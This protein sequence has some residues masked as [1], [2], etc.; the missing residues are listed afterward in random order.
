MG[1]GFSNT[2]SY[3]FNA[4]RLYFTFKSNVDANVGT[5]FSILFRKLF[6]SISQ[7]VKNVFDRT[8]FFDVTKAAIRAGWLNNTPVGEFSTAMGIWNEASGSSSTAMGSSSK[9]RGQSSTALGNNC[10]ASGNQSVAMGNGAVAS[11]PNAIALGAGTYATSSSSVAMGANTT[12]SGSYSTAMG[13]STIASGALSFAAGSEVN[14]NLRKGAFAFGDSDPTNQGETTVGLDDQ[15]VCRFRSGYYFLTSGNNVAT[16]T[17]VFVVTG[18]NSWSAVSDVRLK[19]NFLPVD[20]ESFL[21][22]ISLIPQY[23][24][25]YKGQ[26]SKTFRHYGPMAQDFY[27]A[28]GKDR[29]GSIGCDTLINQQDFLGVNLIVVQ[30]LEK[31]TRLL[32]NENEE[33]NKRIKLLE[34]DKNRIESL[35]QQL[36]L[37]EEQIKKVIHQRN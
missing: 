19:E 11:G 4:S 30:A 37:L 29:L 32:Q 13:W 24:W 17:G 5:G 18:G 3:I 26:D 35:Q 15:F 10:L 22:K 21:E 8:F 20:G 34:T 23:T 9:A 14:T 33:L 6:G 7:P 2:G 25:N 1:N 28:F 12:A 31:R 36:Q 16:R 27:N